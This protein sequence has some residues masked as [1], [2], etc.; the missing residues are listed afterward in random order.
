M[1]SS[2]L[3]WE[4]SPVENAVEQ[5]WKDNGFEATLLKRYQTKSVYRVS[6]DGITHEEEI[7]DWEESAKAYITKFQKFWDG[8]VETEALRRQL[9]ELQDKQ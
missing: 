6:R 7:P 5:Y 9:R 1:A 4:A 8:L 3:N 2:N